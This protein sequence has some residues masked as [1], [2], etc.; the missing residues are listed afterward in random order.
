MHDLGIAITYTRR[1]ALGAT[2]GIGSEVDDDAMS[3]IK[4]LP[5]EEK[6]EFQELLANQMNSLNLLNL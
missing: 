3:L 6:K 2:Y 4:N 5:L 1:Y